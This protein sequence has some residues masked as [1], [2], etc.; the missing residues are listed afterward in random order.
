MFLVNFD[1]LSQLFLTLLINDLIRLRHSIWMSC[2]PNN[3]NK[4]IRSVMMI[5]SLIQIIH[6][7]VLPWP[8]YRMVIML[9][10]II[11]ASCRILAYYPHYEPLWVIN[12]YLHVCCRPLGDT[13]IDLALSI[14]YTQ[15]QTFDFH[16]FITKEMLYIMCHV[17]FTFV[18]SKSK[19]CV[20]YIAL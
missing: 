19:I 8:C 1:F 20:T 7:S 2:R 12:Y 10:L 16:S 4:I 5:M 6:A 14:V 18:L 3:F 9:A 13:N 11:M 17:L 15:T